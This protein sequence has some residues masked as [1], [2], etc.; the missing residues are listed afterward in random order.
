[1]GSAAQSTNTRQQ[2]ADE[3]ALSRLVERCH[4]GPLSSTSVGAPALECWLEAFPRPP[5]DAAARPLTQT[6]AVAA[7]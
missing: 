2:T 7:E 4:K 1:M 5:H 6:A 3:V